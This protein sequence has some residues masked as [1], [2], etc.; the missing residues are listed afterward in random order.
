MKRIG[1]IDNYE[2]GVIYRVACWFDALGL[3]YRA[4]PEITNCRILSGDAC[5]GD[6]VFN[7]DH[8][9]TSA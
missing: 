2:C 9:V 5:G 4:T 3:T 6:F 8:A 1:A 7:F